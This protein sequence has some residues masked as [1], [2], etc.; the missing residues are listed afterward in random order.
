MLQG[1]FGPVFMILCAPSLWENGQ[2]ANLA[3]AAHAEL[4]WPG[5]E[6]LYRAGWPVTFLPVLSHIQAL[7]GSVHAVG[8]SVLV[9]SVVSEAIHT[10]WKHYQLFVSA[11][12][13]NLSSPQ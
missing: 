8:W 1:P 11:G 13:T 12:H 3:H 10:V 2:S 9:N 7:C 5:A 4:L 6:L